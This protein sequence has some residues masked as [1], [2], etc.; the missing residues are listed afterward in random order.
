MNRS[1][2]A[3]I[4]VVLVFAPVVLTVVVAVVPGVSGYVVA[5]GSMDP[6]IPQGSYA[7][8]TPSDEYSEGDVITFDRGGTV[9][10][11]R[12]VDRRPSGFVTAGDA[13]DALDDAVVRR[14]AIRGE[15]AFHLPLYGRL[16][17][18]F[19]TLPGYLLLVVCPSVLLVRREL[20]TVFDGSG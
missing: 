8:V 17:R 7:V 14:D 16:L 11:H 10:T 18:A 5:S 13:N 4:G 1:H 6:T 2:L 19:D 20:S 15:V 9:V 3:R 12:I